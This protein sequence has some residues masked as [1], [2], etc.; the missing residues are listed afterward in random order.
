M[1][2]RNSKMHHMQQ[3]AYEGFDEVVAFATVAETGSFKAAGTQL[4]RDASVISRRLSQL[5][6]RLGVRLLVR[7]T[8]SVT[9]TEAGVF[10]FRRVRS[11]IDELDMATREVGDFAATPQGVLKISLPVTFGRE[12]IAPLLPDFLIKFPQIRIDAH[13]L[14][15]TVDVV[16]EG[17]DAVIRIGV[18]RDST[19][20]SKRVGSFRSLLVASSSYAATHALPSE[21]EDLRA[22]ACLGYTTHPDWPNWVLE[23]DGV[24]ETVRPDGP[25]I[26]NSS[27]AQ[28]VAAVKGLGI[29]LTPQWLAA[30]YL[31]TG[32]LVEVLPGWRS[33]RDINIYIVMPPG[34]LVP[35]KTRM[36]VDE[37]SQALRNEEAWV[38]R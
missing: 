28:L 23:K 34:A 18:V 21:L 29:A 32:Q 27:E 6:R 1:S 2:D 3:L 30:P 5:E 20:I 7:T 35:A 17:F 11:V 4:G 31:S 12:V 33:V 16:S 14:D 8:R 9:L 37:L 15:R 19:L 24:R 22:H 36:L 38:K 13:F 26:A 25:L 10:Y